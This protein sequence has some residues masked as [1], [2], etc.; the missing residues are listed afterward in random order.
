MVSSSEKKKLQLTLYKPLK[1]YGLLIYP[2]DH[3]EHF[4]LNIYTYQWLFAVIL[5]IN[6]FILCFYLKITPK[7]I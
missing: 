5:E 3:L 4:K 7:I 1:W 6:F 2:F